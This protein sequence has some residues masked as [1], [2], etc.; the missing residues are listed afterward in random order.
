MR[1]Q[2]TRNSIEDNERREDPCRAD[3]ARRV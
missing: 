3:R 2:S 1:S